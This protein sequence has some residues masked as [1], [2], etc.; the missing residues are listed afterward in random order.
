M[1]GDTA[2]IPPNLLDPEHLK[3]PYEGYARLRQDSPVQ[4]IAPG[5]IFAVRGADDVAHVLRHPEI[6][7]SQ[8]FAAALNPEWLPYPNPLRIGMITKDGAEHTR[9]RTLVNRAFL[10]KRVAEFE[11]RVR[12]IAADLAVQLAG[13]D[14]DFVAAYASQLPSRVIAE[15]VGLDEGGHE[16][17]ERWV[18]VIEAINIARPDDA[19][20][21]QVGQMLRESDEYFQ[22][23]V[24]A[25]RAQP[26]DDMVSD[27]VQS[28]VD[29]SSLSDEELVAILLTL[30]IGGSTR[31]SPCS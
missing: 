5:G 17:L 3:N 9:L 27:L 11:P 20:V 7:S 1:Q 22:Q 25:R 29:G 14:V 4:E 8:G 23:L 31:R 10:P 6:Y 21:E 26:R 15:V 13:G 12:A 2:A 19:T 30:A 16:S 24:A 28:S 18:P